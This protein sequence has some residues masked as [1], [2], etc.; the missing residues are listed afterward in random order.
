MIHIVTKYCINQFH[1]NIETISEN[2]KAHTFLLSILLNCQ[3]PEGLS[4]SSM[5]SFI[6]PEKSVT[7]AITY[8]HLEC[9]EDN[10]KQNIKLS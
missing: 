1:K 7:T 8:N 9:S 3:R 4:V 5:M 6:T 10:M 2:H